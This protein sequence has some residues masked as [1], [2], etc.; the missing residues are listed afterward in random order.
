MDDFGNLDDT[1]YRHDL[2]SIILEGEVKE[3]G[4]D[5]EFAR[6]VIETSRVFKNGDGALETELCCYVVRIQHETLIKAAKK[7]ATLGRKVRV[8]GRLYNDSYKEMRVI[9]IAEHI[10][11][12]PE[13]KEL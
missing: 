4:F 3:A 13:F 12:R 2:N 5:E 10:E 9:V 1:D 6:L 11:F 7:H 8:V